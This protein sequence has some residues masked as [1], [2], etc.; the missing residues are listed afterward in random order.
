MIQPETVVKIADN[1]G[2]K[3]GKVFK[4]L[5]GS[6]KRYARIGDVVVMSED[7]K[8]MKSYKAYD[9]KV[10]GVISTAPAATFG[11]NMG[12]VPLAISGRVPVKVTDENGP[13]EPGDLLTTS[14]TLGHAMKCNDYKRCFGNI[15]GKAIT[16]LEKEQ[17]IV[18]MM[19][20]LN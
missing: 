5:G 9:K 1:S 15:I 13:I 12:N 14:S 8:V 4:I 19:I 11:G 10:V 16:P 18:T 2:A 6:R 20:M 17:G 3:V 7:M